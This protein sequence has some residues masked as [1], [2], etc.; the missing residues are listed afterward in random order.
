MIKHH[1][2]REQ[3]LEYMECHELSS[4][5]FSADLKKAFDSIEHSF[6]IVVFEKFGLEPDLINSVKTLFT[7]AE[8]CMM[9]NGHSIGYFHLKEEPDK[10]I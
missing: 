10:E 7:G 8:S 4:I 3:T 2:N 5:L 1:S 9:N 6:I